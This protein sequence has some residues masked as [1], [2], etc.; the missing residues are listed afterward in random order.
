VKEESCYKC[1]SKATGREHVPPLCIFPEQKDVGED[2]RK[3]LITVPSCDEHNLKKSKDDEF[4]MTFITGYIKNNFIGYKQTKSKLKRALDRKYDG[5][6]NSVLKDAR[7]LTI[8]NS[9]GTAFSVIAGTP[10]LVR[11]K[12]CIEQISCGLYYYEY[13][14]QFKGEFRV[15]YDFVKYEDDNINKLIPYFHDVYK[16][17][18][19][20]YPIKGDNSEIFA[21]QITPPNEF[22]IIGLKLSFFEGT[23]FFVSLQ[24]ENSPE[25]FDLGFKMIEEGYKTTIKFDGKNYDFN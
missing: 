21:Y 1:G 12:K 15:V 14:K 24:F 3:N 2:H 16:K 9:N 7:E 25:P 8:K 5:F 10:N 17:A 20:T 23:H 22:G 19:N 18:A 4:L 13:G 11:I 6:I